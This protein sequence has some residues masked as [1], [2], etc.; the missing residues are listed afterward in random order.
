MV[1]ALGYS[2]D[3]FDPADPGRLCRGRERWIE[4]WPCD[5][6]G[7]LH[8]LVISGATF[9]D[10]SARD[11]KRGLSFSGLS[12]GKVLSNLIDGQPLLACAEEGHAERVPE[13]A[14]SVEYVEHSQPG[15][16]L[17]GWSA[18]WS[19]LCETHDAIDHAVDCGADV[20]LLASDVTPSDVGTPRG[21]LP[22]EADEP[23]AAKGLPEAV[24][25]QLF[26]LMGF[27]QMRFPTRRFQPAALPDLLGQMSQVILVHQDKHAPCLAL[28]REGPFERPERL[29]ELATDV[30]ALPVPFAI[31][32]MLARW[33]RALWEL[34][35]EWQE[36]EQGE[37]PVPASPDDAPSWGRARQRARAPAKATEE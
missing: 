12:L 31:P 32:P 29:S 13:E 28:Y 14:V 33:D 4:S 21:S 5:T 23:D 26:L 37:F 7:N 1:R 34:R 10:D 15:G 35:Q 19:M 36:V 11:A 18:R 27:R 2:H 6:G 20:F 8:R 3:P 25:E 9:S 22:P 24:R 17:R 16:P 30:G